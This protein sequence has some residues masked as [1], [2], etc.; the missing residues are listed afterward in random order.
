M[1]LLLGLT[2]FCQD[3]NNWVVLSSNAK[4]RYDH[5]AWQIVTLVKG[6]DTNGDISPVLMELVLASSA[7]CA[8]SHSAP[9]ITLPQTNKQCLEKINESIGKTKKIFHRF[10]STTGHYRA[11]RTPS[12]HSE[13]T[14][15]SFILTKI[16]VCPSLPLW[17]AVGTESWPDNFATVLKYSELALF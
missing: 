7:T 5:N 8:I 6:D 10:H 3:R 11:P 2:D 12:E 14:A 1:A 15:C 17:K 16:N 9:S 13:S 4:M